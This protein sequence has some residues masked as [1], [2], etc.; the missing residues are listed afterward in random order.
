V[1]TGASF[2]SS[3]EIN[4]GSI[5][6]STAAQQQATLNQKPKR[7]SVEK[8]KMKEWRTRTRLVRY[9]HFYILPLSLLG[10]SKFPES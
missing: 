7:L 6:L 5:F 8:Y 1:A 3:F 2:T 4:D 9:L 10:G